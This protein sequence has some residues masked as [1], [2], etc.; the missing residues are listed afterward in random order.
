[1][2][3]ERKS[4]RMNIFDI[5]GPVMVGPSSSHTAGAVRIGLISRKLMNEDIIKADI[6]FHG[7]FFYTGKGHGT[8]LAIIAGLLGMQADDERIPHSFQ[9]ADELEM[10]YSFSGIQLQNAHPNSA[11]LK[12]TG[13]SGKYLEI[14][15]SSLG[16][17]RI[18]V[19][20][21]DGIDVNFSGDYPTLIVHNIDE[22][23]H[24]ADVTSMLRH[25]SVN[26]A[27]MQLYRQN[28]GGYAVMVL[29]CDQE[30]PP[31]AIN[32]LERVEGVMK[33]SYYSLLD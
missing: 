27:Q 24:I 21:I 9:L 5:I 18:K 33:V 26:V 20:Q 11:L 3:S 8:D 15:G 10:E 17:G 29:E 12:L 22:P 28:R 4:E 2:V 19:N 6:L 30:I 13:I 16:G 32:W 23:G 25:K 1:M 7:S 14:V 31:E